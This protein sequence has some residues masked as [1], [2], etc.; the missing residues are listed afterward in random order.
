MNGIYGTNYIP[1][2]QGHRLFLI[3]FAGAL[4]RPDLSNPFRIGFLAVLKLSDIDME[5]KKA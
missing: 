2:F 3:P 1:P 4:P 5:Q